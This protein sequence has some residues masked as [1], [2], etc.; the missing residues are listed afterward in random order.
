MRKNVLSI[1]FLLLVG[2][3]AVFFRIDASYASI[4]GVSPPENGDW[5][6]NADTVVEGETI[7][8]NGSI[9]HNSNYWFNVSNSDIT[10]NG[11]VSAVTTYS[12]KACWQ[13]SNFTIRDAPLSYHPSRTSVLI[14]SNV[15]IVNGS[16][17]TIA[18]YLAGTT[19][20]IDNLTCSGVGGID[21]I[22]GSS[23]H[24]YN[25]Y[26]GNVSAY[27]RPSANSNN[28]YNWTID[29]WTGT[30]ALEM[31]YSSVTLDTVNI[32]NPNSADTA[33]AIG[34]SNSSNNYISNVYIEGA[35]IT[36][37][38]HGIYFGG[39]G[40]NYGC[41]N[42]TVINVVLD[43]SMGNGVF[44][45]YNL[46]TNYIINATI[47]EAYDITDGGTSSLGGSIYVTDSTFTDGNDKTV[48]G[49]FEGGGASS[50]YGFVYQRCSVSG[51]TGDEAYYLT[52]NA[53]V[54]AY[55]M[56]YNSLPSAFCIIEDSSA[57]LLQKWSFADVMEVSVN[58]TLT[59]NGNA[60][61]WNA[62]YANNNVT[63]SLSAPSG[64]LT[65]QVYCPLGI[66]YF[67][68][69]VSSW[70]FDA[71]TNITTVV[72]VNQAEITLDFNFPSE[73]ELVINQTLQAMYF[74]VSIIGFSLLSFSCFALIV[75][76]RSNTSN[77]IA[78][79]F[80][81]ILLVG[82]VIAMFFGLTL[83]A[84]FQNQV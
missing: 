80:I 17:A 68:T 82:S 52:P 33:F 23:G 12:H 83:A 73:A 71:A 15:R 81:I 28:N 48:G 54:L 72:S 6:I 7:I 77:P 65:S 59:Q 70:S 66:P 26:F 13:N 25:C 30:A 5:I 84:G 37:P 14:I 35:G 44:R 2:T 1:I 57:F 62:T 20:L 16:S 46:G 49:D 60:T 79:T 39:Y 43:G 51:T 21:S 38:H 27:I 19:V 10:V 53:Q 41:N 8:V 76:L 55:N 67:A 61:L 58:T 45:A 3:V 24:V 50:D 11:N 34:F 69:G 78:V 74:A 40:G 56:T 4:T 36:N 32:I 42:N 75:L 22:G 64:T 63:Y 18:G 47:N 29:T 9:V 31:R